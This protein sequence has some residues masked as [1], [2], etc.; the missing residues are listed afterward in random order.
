MDKKYSCRDCYYIGCYIE[1]E[2]CVKCKWNYMYE[3]M[4]RYNETKKELTQSQLCEA[5][6]KKFGKRR[7]ISFDEVKEVAREIFE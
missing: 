6:E 2:P 5:F 7:A 1:D 3:D 4:Y